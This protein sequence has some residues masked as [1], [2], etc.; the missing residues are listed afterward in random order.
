MNPEHWQVCE[1]VPVH[2]AGMPGWIGMEVLTGS[3]SLSFKNMAMHS[4]RDRRR[5]PA[6]GSGRRF[7]PT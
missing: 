2:E 1:L 4:C 7:A 3:G 5:G 6:P